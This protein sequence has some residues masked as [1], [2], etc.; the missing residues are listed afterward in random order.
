[1]RK[2][3]AGRRPRAV[4]VGAGFAGLWAAKRLARSPVDVPLVDR[5]NYHLFL[6]LLYQVAAAELEAEDIACPVRSVLRDLPNVTFV[7]SEVRRIDPDAREVETDDG[8]IPF[9]YLVLAAGSTSHSFGIPGAPECSFPLKTLGESV[10][11]RNRILRSSERAAREPDPG[12]RR[13]ALTFVIFVG[14]ATGVEFSGALLSVVPPL[15]VFALH[16]FGKQAQENLDPVPLQGF[17]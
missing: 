3:P 16:L 6:P 17:S 7:L 10:A 2:G 9:D 11:L 8:K 4:I 13:A 15:V 5:N 14:G 1:M 12:R